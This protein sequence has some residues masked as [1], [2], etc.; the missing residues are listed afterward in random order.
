VVHSFPEACER[1]RMK[2]SAIPSGPLR[3]A[4][5]NGRMVRGDI[6]S[7]FPRSER[8]AFGGRWVQRNEIMRSTGPL[9][10]AM[11]CAFGAP[12]A[13]EA[14]SPHLVSMQIDDARSG[15][16][17]A[18]R[19]TDLDEGQTYAK[20]ASS[21][22]GDVEFGLLACD[23]LAPSMDF[24]SA[25]RYARRASNADTGTEFADELSRAIRSFNNGI[26]GINLGLCK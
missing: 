3:S 16:Q 23:C 2:A 20:R 24:S 11:L 6:T 22:L 4:V 8:R 9:L 7:Q 14:C 18:S 17:R 21:A 13:A 5:A 19:A 26:N 12:I 25:H 10:A 1:R 15:L